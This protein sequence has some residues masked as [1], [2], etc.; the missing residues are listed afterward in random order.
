MKLVCFVPDANTVG[1]KDASGAFLPDARAFARHHGCEP[2]DVVVRFPA[3]SPPDRRR[4]VCTQMLRA[5]KDLEVVAFFCHGWPDGLQAGFQRPHIL[6]LAR[7]LAA[8]TVANAH[9]LLYACNAGRDRDADA[10][11]DL[12]TGPG[13]DGGFADE[14][15]DA[16]DS[17]KARITV[18]AHASAGHT[19]QNPYVRYFAPGDSQGGVWYVEPKSELWPLWVRALRDP[20]STLRW[21]FWGMTR[22]AIA[23]EL[24]GSGPLV[25]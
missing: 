3:A 4:W 20:Q 19:T 2:D 11:D 15:R 7:L 6:T 1:R 16:C 23:A 10:L 14:L 22:E 18:T 13:G 21:R 25:A 24:R 9:V 17:M 12:Q 8:S 5:L